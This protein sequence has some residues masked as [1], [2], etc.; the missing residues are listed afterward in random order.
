MS[1][2]NSIVGDVSVAALMAEHRG[3]N[4]ALA[5]GKGTRPHYVVGAEVEAVAL[6]QAWPITWRALNESMAKDIH[7]LL[8]INP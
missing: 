1:A 8:R 2:S 3:F 6:K 5:Y 7:D 4:N